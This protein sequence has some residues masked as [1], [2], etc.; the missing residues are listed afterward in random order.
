MS[1]STVKKEDIEIKDEVIE[2]APV[3]AIEVVEIP[4]KKERPV[5]IQKEATKPL[6]ESILDFAAPRYN[7]KPLLINDFLK[8]TVPV[9]IGIGQPEWAKQDF[10]KKVRHALE[11][12]VTDR[13][14]VVQSDVHTR[15]GKAFY[16]G[17][18]PVTQYHSIASLPIYI[19]LI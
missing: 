7:G 3:S 12:L 19:E 6:Y 8:S 10:S 14:I 17:D 16:H 5:I 11:K 1:K 15:L 4:E 9:H 2:E 13:K 18:N